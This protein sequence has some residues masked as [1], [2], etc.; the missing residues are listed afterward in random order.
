MIPTRQQLFQKLFPNEPSYRWKQA[1]SGLFSQAKG[2]K[3]VSAFP[4]FL[5]EAVEKDISW[6]SVQVKTIEK[7]KDNETIK[8]L[9]Q[10]TDGLE[11]ESVLMRNAR[12]A[13][14]ICISSQVGCAMR[15]AFCSTGAMGLK[16]QLSQD[17]I[18]DQYRFWQ[19]Y[20]I[21]EQIHGR[22]SNIVVMGMGEPMANYENVR[23]AL[24]ILCEYTDVG[25]TKITV[26][27]AG[28]FASLDHLLEDTLWPPVR[29]AISLHS[30]DPLVRPRIMPSTPYD[31]FDHL[32]DWTKAYLEKQG[33]RTHHLTFEYILLD[34]INDRPEDAKKL[35]TFIHSID[36]HRIR[37]NLIPYNKAEGDLRSSTKKQRDAFQRLLKESDI[38][39]TLRTSYGQEISAAC[40]QLAG[41]S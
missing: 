35:I 41:K 20:K 8:S 34:G 5:R 11:I 18:V 36:S 27:T 2:W 9:L 25:P 40:G 17:E 10:L 14:T 16:R 28:I 7:T 15:C 32:R 39:T 1:L 33:N 19:Q 12:D 37:V 13:W 23:D 31:F 26:S 30:A 38:I 3:E 21:Q 29:M 6:I 24:N 22:I 4:S